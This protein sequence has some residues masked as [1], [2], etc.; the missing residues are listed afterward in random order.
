VVCKENKE[1]RIEVSQSFR[2]SA[3]G[4]KRPPASKKRQQSITAI[5]L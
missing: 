3:I 2:S 1:R 4:S 5:I